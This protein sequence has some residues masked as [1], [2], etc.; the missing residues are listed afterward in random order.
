[1]PTWPE[2]EKR[3]LELEA[4]LR[5]ARLDY[6]GGAAGEYWRVAAS[7]DRI[8]TSRF[9]AISKL[10]GR[11]LLVDA[12]SEDALPSD[13]RGASDDAVRWY[14][15]MKLHSGHY[16]HG[17]LGYQ[18]HDDGTY[19]GA[20]VSGHIQSPASVAATLCLELSSMSIEPPAPT[21]PFS[22]HVSG[23]NARVNVG[24]TD[25]S[26]NAYT[27]NTT[28]IFERLQN[29]V[30]EHIPLEQRSELLDRINHME[31]AVDTPSFISRYNDFIQSAA[32][33]IAVFGPMLPA[34]SALL[35]A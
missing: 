31:K 18:T 30:T 25:N 12:R 2:L 13:L 32:N 21:S 26:T 15:A 1:M 16:E 27:S 29:A 35:K 10:A 4:Q 8:A 20:I 28:S 6:Q 19:A 24:S 9:E 5:G 22:I 11:K 7:F 34:L 17:I 33:H 14:R 3:F 23:V